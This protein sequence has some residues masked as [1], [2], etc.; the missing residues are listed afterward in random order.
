MRWRIA[1]A[2]AAV[3]LPF[4]AVAVPAHL[5]G[6]AAAA[7]PACA[8]NFDQFPGEP[9]HAY[10]CTYGYATVPDGTR[11]AVA[12]S[13]PVGYRAGERL[14]ALF[15]VD[16]YDGGGGALDPN[17]YGNR[18]VM[19]HASLRGTGCSGG[20]FDLFSWTDAQ[21]AASVV[22][23][24]IPRQRWS[25]GRVGIIGHSYPGLSGFMT[26]ERIGYDERLHPATVNHLYGLALSGLIDDL[27]R[28][29][30][31][32]GGVPDYGFPL[33]WAGAYRPASELSGNAGRYSGGDTT[34]LSNLA[35]RPVSDALA[36]DTATDDP[37]VNGLTQ[38]QDSPWWSS[39]SLITYADFIN[40]PI[41]IDQQYQDEQ[42][43]PR[44]G[45]LLFQALSR[46]APDLPKRIVFTNGRHD[47]AGHVYHADEQAWLDCYVAHLDSACRRLGSPTG[48][49]R[50]WRSTVRGGS[51]AMLTPSTVIPCPGASVVAYFDTTPAV[52]GAGNRLISNGTSPPVCSTSFPLPGTRWRVLHMTASGAL[53]FRP[54]RPGSR[55]YLSSAIGPDDYVGPTEVSQIDNPSNQLYQQAVGPVLSSPG[56]EELFWSLPVR[57]ETTIMGPLMVDLDASVAGVDAD[58]F[59]QLID[60]DD[61]TGAEQ[62]LQYGLLRA[63]YVR[64]L[65]PALS[66]YAAG[67]M[68]R[69]YYTF[70][71]PSPLTPGRMTQY[72]IE[73]FPLGWVLRPGHSLLLS[74]SAPPAADQLYAWAGEET[75]PVAVTVSSASYL[76]L[77]LLPSADNPLVGARQPA[78]GTQ[79]GIRCTT[80]AL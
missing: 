7:G 10:R 27:Y 30:V 45:A 50:T 80:P 9:E 69:P 78:C 11:I 63:S 54:G 5:A 41:H 74:V 22:N 8:Q 43:G 55:T 76:L 48:V 15:M 37:I 40:A 19:V 66:D 73:V 75:P 32:V 51:T 71:N 6:L 21:D 25:D 70:T 65:D 58:F 38:Q 68:Y 2:L 62:F 23:Q 35:T 53:S 46:L 34:C 24:W 47:S 61:R 52:V 28:G 14:P 17:S 1:F 60:R 36:P 3:G 20:Q 42:T 26:A 12:V 13:Y 57:T 59:V 16:G 29:I 77:P 56:P 33:V 64:S 39:H 72:R 44:G 4:A 67:H 49:P 79:E 18:Y 31:Y